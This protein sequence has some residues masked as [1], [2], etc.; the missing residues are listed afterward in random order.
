MVTKEESERN[1]DIEGERKIESER[2][3]NDKE[4]RDRVREKV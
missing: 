2:K 3:K 4:R 1:S